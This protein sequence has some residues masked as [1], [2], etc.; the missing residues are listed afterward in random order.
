MNAV[1][2]IEFLSGRL[3]PENFCKQIDDEV[4]KYKDSYKVRG[5]SIPIFLSDNVEKFIITKNEVIRIC[6][7]F[8]IGILSNW[9]VY[10]I[11]DAIQ[12][13]TEL[14]IENERLA[15]LISS[16]TDP[17]VNGDLTDETVNEIKELL[18]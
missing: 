18:R 1:S 6:D 12:L 15:G 14:L 11:C 5:S 3:L 4:R 9:H 17:E 10:Y 7:T 8:L 16:M 2:L 13:S